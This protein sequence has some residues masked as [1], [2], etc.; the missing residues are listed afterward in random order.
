M[1]K[2][3]K[4]RTYNT[5][6]AVRIG[7]WDNIDGYSITAISDPRAETKNLYRKK[8]GEY[9]LVIKT[10]KY[11]YGDVLPISN[12]EARN[13][14]Y[15]KDELR[16]WTTEDLDAEFGT[17]EEL[18]KE[19]AKSEELAQQEE[20]DLYQLE[21]VVHKK[22]QQLAEYAKSQDITCAQALGKAIE[23]LTKK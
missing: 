11:W 20:N 19:A 5:D 6:T 14:C 9:F 1:I 3:I 15:S 22:Y 2:K 16:E 17:L 4:G 8:D 7:H 13:F 12:L 10:K 21:R 23:L 18:T